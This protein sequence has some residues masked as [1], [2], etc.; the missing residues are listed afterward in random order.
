MLLQAKKGKTGTEKRAKCEDHPSLLRKRGWTEEGC[1]Y[2]LQSPMQQRVKY[3]VCVYI[4]ICVCV[5]RNTNAPALG[6]V[7]FLFFYIYFYKS[8]HHTD[9]TFQPEHYITHGCCYF[10][11]W[12]MGQLVCS[13]K[14]GSWS[15]LEIFIQNPCQ[16]TFYLIRRKIS[17]IDPSPHR[18]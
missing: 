5:Y 10:H 18:Q 13:R 2:V 6:C 7:L 1:S 9:L 15:Q 12:N 14:Y 4:H 8:V 17:R 16:R 3:C 11:F